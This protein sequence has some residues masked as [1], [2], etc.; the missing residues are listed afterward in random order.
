MFRKKLREMLKMMGIDEIDDEMLDSLQ[1]QLFQFLEL[2][3][4][5]VGGISF[6]TGSILTS[7]QVQNYQDIR[8]HLTSSLQT[9]TPPGKLN[10]KL[11]ITSQC[12]YLTEENQCQVTNDICLFQDRSLWW[13]CE[14]VQSS[15]QGDSEEWK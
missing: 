12:L 14:I 3:D 10:L 6:K 7:V 9:G 13:K 4:T 15:C 8:E 5:L 1:R 11:V 2:D